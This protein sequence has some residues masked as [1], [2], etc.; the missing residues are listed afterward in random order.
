MQTKFRAFFLQALT[1][2]HPGTGQDTSGTVDLPVAREKATGYPVIPAS[3]LKGVLRNGRGLEV[4]DDSAEARRVRAIYGFAGR[5][6]KE[7]Q[8]EDLSQAARLSLTDARLLAL[9]VRSYAGTFALITCP[10]ALQRWQRDA[11]ALGL[12]AELRWPEPEGTQVF[13][14][15]ETLVHQGRVILEDLDLEVAGGTGGLAAKLSQLIFQR[16][17]PYFTSRLAVASSDVFGYFCQ[18]GLEVIARVRLEEQTKT[19]KRGALWYEEAVPAEALFAFFA[20]SPNEEDFT[21]LTQHPVLQLGGEASVG[22]GLVRLL[23]G[24]V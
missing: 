16:E 22:R 18:N 1:P 10:L 4:A 15:G 6:K 5:R 14:D 3:S 23:E 20:L 9:P 19:V 7:D 21:E 13:V 24:R 8:E 11:E 17:E 12:S 2:V